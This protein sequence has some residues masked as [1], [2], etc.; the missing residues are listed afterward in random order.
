MFGYINNIISM[1]K[2]AFIILDM[3]NPLLLFSSFDYFLSHHSH[4]ENRPHNDED[5][6]YHKSNK[7]EVKAPN[8]VSGI[9]SRIRFH[10]FLNFLYL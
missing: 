7:T 10:S 3:V 1:N 9:N 5:N 4:L 6:H 2:M 8:I